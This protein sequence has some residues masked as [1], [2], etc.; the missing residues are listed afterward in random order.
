MFLSI[1]LG[2]NLPMF[3][4]FRVYI[5]F[6][7]LGVVI[8]I[9]IIVEIRTKYLTIKSGVD[10][11]KSKIIEVLEDESGSLETMDAKTFLELTKHGS[12]LCIINGY[13]IDYTDFADYHPG[14]S[15]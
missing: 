13:V 10:G 9:F 14:V 5:F 8:A 7:Y 12:Q 11:L 1:K 4:K 2:Y 6:P 15:I 3:S